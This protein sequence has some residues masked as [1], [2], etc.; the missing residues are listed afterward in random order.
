MGQSVR[1]VFTNTIGNDKLSPNCDYCG[2][3]HLSQMWTTHDR[4][5][6]HR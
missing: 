4:V 6:M 1:G 3:D 5:S 2:L